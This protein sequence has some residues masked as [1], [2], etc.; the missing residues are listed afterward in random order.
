MFLETLL[1]QKIKVSAGTI[2][3]L[4]S[5]GTYSKS[6]T[7]SNFCAIR[8]MPSASN[9]SLAWSSAVLESISGKAVQLAWSIDT[10]RTCRVPNTLALPQT[11]AVLAKSPHLPVPLPS[12]HRRPHAFPE[13]WRYAA[14]SGSTS[15]NMFEYHVKIFQEFLRTCVSVLLQ[16]SM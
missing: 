12:P 14:T 16:G 3:S 9:K 8:T 7:C 11:A 1:C 6:V 4:G 5:A 10:T 13:I 15:L 2:A